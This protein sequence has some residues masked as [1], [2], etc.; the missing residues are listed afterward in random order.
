[1]PFTGQ[2]PQKRMMCNAAGLQRG[3]RGSGQLTDR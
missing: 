1:V 2:R 3:L